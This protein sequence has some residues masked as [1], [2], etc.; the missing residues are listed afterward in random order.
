VAAGPAGGVAV[1]A[2]WGAGEQAA[3]AA[4]TNISDRRSELDT[5]PP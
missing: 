4:A 5:C 3:T 1:P 2:S